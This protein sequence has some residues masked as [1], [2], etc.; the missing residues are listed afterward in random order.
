ML[1]GTAK[2]TWYVRAFPGRCAIGCRKGYVSLSLPAARP[3]DEYPPESKGYANKDFQCPHIRHVAMQKFY[4]GTYALGCQFFFLPKHDQIFPKRFFTQGK[5]WKTLD[6]RNLAPMQ[7][8]M[9]DLADDGTLNVGL[10]SPWYPRGDVKSYLA[11]DP[12]ADH[13]KLVRSSACH[14]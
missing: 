8:W 12:W 4:A 13:N 6:G 1:E 14:C 11:D 9:M 10:V 3:A 7:G 2:M 5:K